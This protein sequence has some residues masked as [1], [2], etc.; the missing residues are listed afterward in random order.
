MIFINS[1]ED[2]KNTKPVL[3]ISKEWMF[4]DTKGDGNLSIIYLGDQ[5]HAEPDNKYF[6]YWYHISSIAKFATLFL[7]RGLEMSF[8][9]MNIN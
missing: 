3:K 4:M 7:K 5:Q 2:P 1:Y 8:L 9:Q 6:C